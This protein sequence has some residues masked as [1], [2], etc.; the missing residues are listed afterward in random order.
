MLN[1]GSTA[2]PYEPYGYKI[3]ILIGRNTINK[4]LGTVQTVRQIKK[5]VLTGE[6]NCSRYDFL[7]TKGVS[8][9]NMLDT[10]YSRTNGLCSHY[11]VATGGALNSL[12]IGVNDKVLYF[13]GIL[14][15]LGISSATDFKT[16]LSQQY[17]NGTPVTVW[18]VLA[19]LT[20]GITN[21]P[22]MKIDNYSDSLTTSIPCTAG[23]NTLDVQ[24][25]IQPSE[26][27]A[28]FE[29]WHPVQSVHERENG[30]WD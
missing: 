8:V 5:L 13:V 4:Y 3:P 21:E 16:Y 18:Y 1:T 30:Q 26:V 27:T 22:L 6:E 20:T 28:T 11:P 25:T 7:N 29:G 24:T 9:S 10:N 15:A 19:T 17:A 14:D 12:W 23:E 2:L